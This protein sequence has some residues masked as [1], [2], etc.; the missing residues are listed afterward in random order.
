M[1]LHQQ[2]HVTLAARLLDG[3][4]AAP[5]MGRLQTARCPPAPLRRPSHQR[6][7][8]PHLHHVL[9]VAALTREMQDICNCC[10]HSA[11]SK[12]CACLLTLD[13]FAYLALQGPRVPRG[14]TPPPAP[15]EA[16]PSCALKQSPL[17]PHRPGQTTFL[18]PMRPQA[19]SNEQSSLGTQDVCSG[20]V[21][22]AH[23]Q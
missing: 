3:T 6:T 21:R 23:R 16:A 5:G 11:D 1:W 15:L 13:C 19:W 12:H 20:L 18:W 9:T 8:R 22:V 14:Q 4:R 7:T 17:R 2:Q 10:E